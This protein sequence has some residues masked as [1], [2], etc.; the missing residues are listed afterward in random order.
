M[1]QEQILSRRRAAIHNLL[2]GYMVIGFTIVNGIVLVPLYLRF[3]SL[4]TYGVW[5]ASGN[6][7]GLLGIFSVGINLVLMQR[8]AASYSRSDYE[9]F[10]A[11]TGSGAILNA[12]IAVIIV[13]LVAVISPRIPIWLKAESGEYTPLI[14]GFVMAGL[15]SAFTLL[16][17][18]LHTIVRARQQTLFAGISNVVALVIGVT[19]TVWG[20]YAG[21]SVAAIGLGVML[22]G[23]SGMLL[24]LLYL[25]KVWPR[26]LMPTIR[27]SSATTRELGKATLP[28][29]LSRMGNVFLNNSQ[30]TIITILVNPAAAAIYTLTGRVFLLGY[31]VL[32]SIGPAVISGLAHFSESETDPVRIRKLLREIIGLFSAASAFLL[33]AA[34]ALNE[35]FISLWVGSDKYG[36]FWLALFICISAVLKSRQ[37]LLESL[38]ASLNVIQEAA[39]ASIVELLVQLALIWL[40]A[41]RLGLIGIPIAEAVSIL[42]VTGWFFVRLLS[43]RIGLRAAAGLRLSLA[44]HW[45]LLVT[46]IIGGLWAAWTPIPIG[47]WYSFIGQAVVAAF[48]VGGFVL[49]NSP[50]SRPFAR[51]LWRRV[52][53]LDFR[54]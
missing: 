16:Q 49:S 28:V 42:L 31:S 1:T 4:S 47:N 54:Q 18:F 27:F 8:F 39:W 6:I 44:G 2:F 24:I 40:L 7:V 51:Q 20:L 23:L 12:S 30:A 29:T 22:R 52:S 19:A 41:N 45:I 34:L 43:R 38:L 25:V 33:A 5:L 21:L 46:L 37:S 11:L 15:G 13:I 26:Q 53:R 35:S 50:E 48:L 9:E 3:F 10:A 14:A 17:V 36:G 32:Q